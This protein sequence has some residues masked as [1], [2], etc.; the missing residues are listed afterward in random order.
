M[1]F[2]RLIQHCYTDTFAF[3][4]VLVVVILLLSLLGCSTENPLCTDNYCVEGE[5]YLKSDLEEDQSYDDVPA[6]VSEQSLVNLF[7]IQTPGDFES[8]TV[9]GTLDWDFSSEDWQYREDRV[10]YLKKVTLEILDEGEFGENRVLL[11][12][13]NK[14]TVIR[15]A[16]SIEHV[17]FLGTGRIELTEW[18]NVGKF[19]GN[20]VGAPVKGEL[21]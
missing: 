16:D 19:K 7:S 3:G 14:D 8:T 18:V 11:I 9:T 6:N 4:A 2:K 10:T 13:L 1:H 15:D 21:D 17:D 12:L 20:I 5:I